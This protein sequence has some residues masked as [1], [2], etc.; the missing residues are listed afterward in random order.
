MACQGQTL[1]LIVPIHKFKENKLFLKNLLLFKM[2]LDYLLSIYAVS[3]KHTV[4]LPRSSLGFEYILTIL[5][6]VIP[7][8]NLY[9]SE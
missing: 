5:D 6:K 2:T 1:Q 9:Y 8:T 4:L 7:A 3:N